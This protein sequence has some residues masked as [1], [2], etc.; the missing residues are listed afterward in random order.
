MLFLVWQEIPSES[1]QRVRKAGVPA[2]VIYNST[3]PFT[4]GGKNTGQKIVPCGKYQF[5]LRMCSRERTLYVTAPRGRSGLFLPRSDDLN[6]TS[7]FVQIWLGSHTL[8]DATSPP[9]N[10][11]CLLTKILQVRLQT[12]AML[13]RQP[14]NERCVGTEGGL[15]IYDFHQHQR[16]PKPLSLSKTERP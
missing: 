4:N 8:S 10:Q 13:N 15:V 14:T 9:R 12:A 11:I 1:S 7:C 6:F 16:V 5:E 2:G 3:G